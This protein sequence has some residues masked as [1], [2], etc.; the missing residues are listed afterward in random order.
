MWGERQVG[1]DSPAF[2]TSTRC[3]P[4]CVKMME[5]IAL[6]LFEQ[7][8]RERRHIGGLF[9]PRADES[10]MTLSAFF[11]PSRACKLHVRYRGSATVKGKQ[12]ILEV[13]SQLCSLLMWKW[14][15]WMVL[16]RRF[17]MKSGYI[18]TAQAPQT[19]SPSAL[20]SRTTQSQQT[21]EKRPRL[22]R[23][24]A[25]QKWKNGQQL[26]RRGRKTR[27]RCTHNLF[28]WL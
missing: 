11:F 17:R 13:S 28:P 19:N 27:R 16:G 1:S 20:T 18:P 3:S 24:G 9:F 10:S 4:Y 22:L 23:I 25:L 21:R 14:M 5:Q 7:G 2:A 26:S 15:T 8:G 6:H 12:E